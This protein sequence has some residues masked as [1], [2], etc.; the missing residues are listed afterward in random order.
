MMVTYY[1]ATI[2]RKDKEAICRTFTNKVALEI[3]AHKVGGHF[4]ELA[5]NANI[6][7]F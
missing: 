4:F 2:Y 7:R 3:W 5:V 6:Y 1:T